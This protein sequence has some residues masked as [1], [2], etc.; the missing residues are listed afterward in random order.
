V[1]SKNAGIE[2]NDIKKV[3]LRIARE[4]DFCGDTRIAL[5]RRRTTPPREGLGLWFKHQ[6][7]N[8]QNS[9]ATVTN[10]GLIPVDTNANLQ[11]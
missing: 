1:K 10:P 5:T 2:P 6:Q 11:R 4:E 3:R 8:C 9:S 7:F